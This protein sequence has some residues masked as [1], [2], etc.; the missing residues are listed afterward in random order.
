[1]DKLKNFEGIL[2]HFVGHLEE[3]RT[4][5]DNNEPQEA[6]LP[7]PYQEQLSK[8]QRVLVMNALRPDKAIQSIQIFVEG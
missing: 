7:A 2:A 5:Y 1:M 3:W 4:F 8:F 6:E